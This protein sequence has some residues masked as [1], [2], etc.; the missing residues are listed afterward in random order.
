MRASALI[1]W[2]ELSPKQV[3]DKTEEL[4][5][6]IGRGRGDTETHCLGQKLPSAVIYRLSAEPLRIRNAGAPTSPRRN[7]RHTLN[8]M[9]L[10]VMI[11]YRRDRPPEPLFSSRSDLD[12]PTPLI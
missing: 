4:V 11:I 9:L 2:Y 7:R 5:K 12:C 1:A 6:F 10:F 3:L 8:A